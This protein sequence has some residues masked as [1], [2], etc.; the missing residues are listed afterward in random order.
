MQ[1]LQLKDVQNV[2]KTMIQPNNMG[3]FMAGDAEKTLP[4][5]QQLGMEVIVID[6][7]GKPVAKKLKP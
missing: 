4:G 3:W 5:L 7:N 2:A 1:K 6:T